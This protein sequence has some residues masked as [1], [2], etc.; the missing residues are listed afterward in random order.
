MKRLF[1]IILMTG[2]AGG[3]FAQKT[4]L[5]GTFTGLP[6]GARLVLSEASDNKQ[7]E[8]DDIVFNIEKTTKGKENT[9]HKKYNGQYSVACDLGRTCGITMDTLLGKL[10]DQFL[11]FEFIRH[12]NS[13]FIICSKPLFYPKDLHT[14]LHTWQALLFPAQLLQQELCLQMPHWRACR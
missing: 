13:S 5:S 8:L 2:I 1:I 6:Q 3:L 9:C 4:T 10:L 12:N 14:F 7:S 11:V